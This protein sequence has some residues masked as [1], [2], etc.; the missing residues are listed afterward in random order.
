M[1]AIVEF[2]HLESARRP[3]L[4]DFLR[5]ARLRVTASDAAALEHTVGAENCYSL[6]LG[7]SRR[8]RD[9]A[10]HPYRAGEGSDVYISARFALRFFKSGQQDR[11]GSGGDSSARIA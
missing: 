6:V 3:P 10:E 7:Y 5:F 4:V 11:A 8:R 2:S 1:N 9:F